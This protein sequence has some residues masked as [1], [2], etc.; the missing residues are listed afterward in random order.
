MRINDDEK[1]STYDVFVQNF[2]VDSDHKLTV[3]DVREIV[4]A[5]QK[6]IKAVDDVNIEDLS[7]Q[8]APV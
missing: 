2:N 3:G 1:I 4:D 5:L 6:K 7:N 8:V